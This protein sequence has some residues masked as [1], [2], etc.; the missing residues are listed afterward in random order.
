M[1]GHQGRTFLRGFLLATAAAIALLLPAGTAAAGPRLA[2]RNSVEPGLIARINKVRAAHHLPALRAASLLT[3]AATKHSNNL[4]YS[5]GFRHEF[6]RSGKWVAF[7][8]WIR[9][10]WPGPNYVAWT[11]GEN[12]A[13]GAP[14]LTPAETVRAWMNSPGHRANLLGA[15]TKVGVAVLHV[16]T[17]AGHYR[18]YPQV[19][20]VAAEFG[21]RSG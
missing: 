19:T 6:H 1:R 10:Y 14:D 9:W 20:I 15:W 16:T 4:A 11:A 2:P 18:D 17:P 21:R 8:S 7:G 5:G 3:T 12:L 13:W